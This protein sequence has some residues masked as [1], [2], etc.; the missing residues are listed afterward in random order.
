MIDCIVGGQIL[1]AVS[2]GSMSIVVGIIIVAIITWVVAFCGIGVFHLY[3]RWAWLPQLV[4]LFILVG[5]AAPYFDTNFP[6]TGNTETVNADRLSFFSLCLSAPIAWA[7]SAA[8]YF[9]YY[10]QSTPRWKSFTFALTGLTLAFSFV[11]L[12]G[13][14]LASA[15]FTNPAWEEA[16][17]ISSGALIL[18][19]YSGL[20]GFGKFCAVIVALG[21][22]ANNIPGTYSA[23]LGFQVLGRYPKQIPRY[24]WTTISVIIYLVCAL[25]GRTHLFT[26]FENWL[27]LMGYWVTSFIM[28]VL[29]EDL[30]FRRRKGMDY[31]WSAWEDR[32]SLPIGI[33]ALLAFLAGWVGAV[34]SMD[35]IY[36]VGPLAKMVG[37]DGADMGL[38]LAAGFTLVV[39]PPIRWLELRYFGR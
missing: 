6:S 22:I 31:D 2:G 14:G 17:E 1:S 3:A 32:R 16:Y 37:E 38:Y 34:I 4:V 21:V 36:F 9:V 35:Q 19:G 10:A 20:G 11:Y 23:A 28:I 25:A 30:L 27:A 13:V 5:S 8:D 39:F 33:A 15:T 18:A 26:I 7:P 12:L 29:E 24:I